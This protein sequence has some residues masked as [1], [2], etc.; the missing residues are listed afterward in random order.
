M[1]VDY[2]K[3]LSIDRIIQKIK[4]EVAKAKKFLFQE[5]RDLFLKKNF[6]Y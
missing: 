1:N 3:D 6:V 5:N 2:S 4:K